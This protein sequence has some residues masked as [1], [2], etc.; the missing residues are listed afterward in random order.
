[1]N[2]AGELQLQ[3][4]WD[5]H[6]VVGIEISST[7]PRAA[8]LLDGKPPEEILARLPML[9]SI[10]GRAQLSAGEAALAAARGEFFQADQAA[11]CAVLCEATQEHLWR[12]LY[13]WPRLLGVA[14]LA[15]EFTHWYR[16]LIPTAQSATLAETRTRLEGLA[17]FVEAAVLGMSLADWQAL[18]DPR[19]ITPDSALAGR[20]WHALQDASTS[21]AASAGWLPAAT[22]AEFA[23]ACNG[24]WDQDFERTP[25]WHGQAAETGPL[26]HWQAHPL[27]ARSLAQHGRGARPRLLARLLDL[28]R[29]AG[30]IAGTQAW[31]AGDLID[32]DSLMPGVGIARVETARGTLLHRLALEVHAG[33]ERVRE[34][35]VVAPT[36]WNFHPHGA[37]VAALHNCR[38][39]DQEALRQQARQLMLALDPCVACQLEISVINQH[40]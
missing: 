23:A 7:R 1:M 17:G 22:A 36:E 6:K 28:A 3:V 34:Y 13:D 27:V 25:T 21:G 32:A 9:Y 16:T 38:V 12:L 10:C 33:A 37:F 19:Q 15:Q 5:G 29:C 31:R 40:A 30:Q 8:R 14:P 39:S 26:A 35:S 20:L 18:Q 24:R 11:A 2:P 4:R